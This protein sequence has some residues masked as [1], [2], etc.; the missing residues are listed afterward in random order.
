MGPLSIRLGLIAQKDTIDGMEK[1]V[2]AALSRD[3]E[4]LVRDVIDRAAGRWVLW[5]LFVLA[6]E[7]PLRFTDLKARVTGITQ[8]VLTL[9][10]RHVEREGFV[11]R[12]VFRQ[13]PPRVEYSLTED[14][15]A[16]VDVALPLWV[17]TARRVGLFAAARARF[18]E[19]GRRDAGPR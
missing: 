8:K 6:D 5:T 4:A 1:D 19:G 12:K 2:R 3:D 7:T 15:R 18:D 11:S 14:G 9:T 16:F 10:L 17:W 13:V